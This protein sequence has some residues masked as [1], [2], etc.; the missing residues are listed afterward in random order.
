MKMNMA[1]GL[2]PRPPY[3]Y[4]YAYGYPGV[5]ANAH[6]PPP[7]AYLSRPPHGSNASRS[8]PFP[9]QQKT[10]AG[11][12]GLEGYHRDAQ[13]K[14]LDPNS[15]SRQAFTSSSRIRIDTDPRRS[16]ISSAGGSVTP[17][18][19]NST[20]PSERGSA[21]PDHLAPNFHGHTL[22]PLQRPP[23]AGAHH[24]AAHTS[25]PLHPVNLEGEPRRSIRDSSHQTEQSEAHTAPTGSPSHEPPS[26][27]K[28][29]KVD[30]P[31]LQN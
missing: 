10:H 16:S 1:K 31:H 27:S 23:I 28:R 26:P 29:P 24:L 6:L 20:V 11:H 15:A 22:P 3:P 19:A 18:S 21:R 8:L 30:D 4:P 7:G 12:P 25:A 14:P 5:P 17:G 9:P 13:G 2:P